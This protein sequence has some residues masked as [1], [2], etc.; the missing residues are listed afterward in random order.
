MTFRGD[1]PYPLGEMRIGTGTYH[2]KVGAAPPIGTALDVQAESVIVALN[3]SGIGTITFPHPFPNGLQSCPVSAG[4]TAGGLGFAIA[5]TATLSTVTVQC[6][7]PGGTTCG[8]GNVRIE[9]QA[10]GW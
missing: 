9:Y 5:Q 1:Q 6:Y 10:T 3:G 2:P 8:A 4:D 7:Q